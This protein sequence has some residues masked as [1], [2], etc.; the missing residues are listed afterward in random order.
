MECPEDS[1]EEQEDHARWEFSWWFQTTVH[2]EERID[3]S[4][5]YYTEL[6]QARV[7]GLTLWNP[8]YL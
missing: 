6:Q 1:G 8:G 2:P 4:E 5:G 3:V 7:R